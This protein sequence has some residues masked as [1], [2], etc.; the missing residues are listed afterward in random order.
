VSDHHRVVGADL[1]QTFANLD[2]WRPLALARPFTDVVNSVLVA[3][4]P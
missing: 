1:D 4:R 2:G 3:I